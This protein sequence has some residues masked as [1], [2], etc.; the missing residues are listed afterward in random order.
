M[1][2]TIGLLNY[3]SFVL[4]LAWT[5]LGCILSA[6][7]LISPCIAFVQGNIT[8]PVWPSIIS[9]MS[10]V[11]TASFTLA[12]IG[13]LIMHTSLIGK[14]KTTIEAYEKQDLN[15]WPHDKGWRENMHSVF[16]KD[17]L[18]WFLPRLTDKEKKALLEEHL[19]VRVPKM[20]NV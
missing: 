20:L 5:C 7:L 15:P 2:N 17:P 8:L 4:F 3:K 18:G 6:L 16:G 13:F 9:F 11:F 12:L 1:A 19:N 14:N 10:F